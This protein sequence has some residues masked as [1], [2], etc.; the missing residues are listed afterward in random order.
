[1]DFLFENPIIIVILIGII[2]SLYKQVKGAQPEEGKRTNRPNQAPVSPVGQNK[3]VR[4]QKQ[5]NKPVRGQNVANQSNQHQGS[6]SKHENLNSA[7]R[8]ETQ[9]NKQTKMEMNENKAATQQKE[10]NKQKSLNVSQSNLVDGLI[11]SEVLGPPRA[12]RPHR[13]IR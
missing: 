1:M 10:E 9:E 4:R 3:P 13:S 5:A 7:T 6:A 8:I 12:K 2:S 11:W